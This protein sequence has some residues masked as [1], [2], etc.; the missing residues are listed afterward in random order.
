MSSDGGGLDRIG[1]ARRD[2][3]R[4]LRRDLSLLLGIAL[5][6]LLILVGHALLEAFQPLGDVAHHVG[7]A[8]AA[9]QQQHDHRENQDMPEAETAHVITP[10]YE[11]G[12]LLDLLVPAFQ[13]EFE[14]GLLQRIEQAGGLEVVD[15]RKILARA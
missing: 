5:L 12:L 10:G 6:R 15:P 14:H 7:K 4:L 8:I 2:I 11:V 13:L 3:D 1:T 9:E